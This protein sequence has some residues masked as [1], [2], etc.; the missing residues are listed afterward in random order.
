MSDPFEL[1]RFVKAQRGNYEQ[2]LQELT[3]GRKR[4]HWMWFVFPQIT[5]LGSSPMAQRYAIGSMDEAQ[6]Y[7]RHPIL[8]SRLRTC[9][10]AVNQVTGRS[11]HDIFGAPD[12]AKFRS[13]MTLFALAD[14]ELP[15]FRI[16]LARYF[17][18]EDDPRTRAKLGLS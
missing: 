12:D 4:S 1:A 3:A 6:A 17:D 16:A 18:G 5:G 9:T 11:A 13:S 14:A 2:A 8:G 10:A 7:L 15:E